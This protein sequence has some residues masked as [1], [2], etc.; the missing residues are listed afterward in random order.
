MNSRLARMGM[1]DCE[2]W[3]IHTESPE[4]QAPAGLSSPKSAEPNTASKRKRRKAANRQAANKNHA[5]GVLRSVMKIRTGRAG[6]PLPRPGI[7][8]AQPGRVAPHSREHS[9]KK[10][11]LF[12]RASSITLL[13]RNSAPPRL[14]VRH[15]RWG[16]Q[17]CRLEFQPAARSINTRTLLSPS[18]IAC[19]AFLP[20]SGSDSCLKTRC[21]QQSH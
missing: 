14:C 10:Q 5:P 19:E 21:E 13:V 3:S 2:T 9:P 12:P 16:G 18:A 8:L 7:K 17:F 1:D 11:V 6:P 15:S 4:G 20:W